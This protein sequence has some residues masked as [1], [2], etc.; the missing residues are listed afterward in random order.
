MPYNDII[1]N[2]KVKKVTPQ[3]NSS[4]ETNFKLD[5]THHHPHDVG[6]ELMMFYNELAM[7][8]S[9]RRTRSE[10]ARVLAEDLEVRR[11]GFA[12]YFE[13]S[14]DEIIREFLNAVA[15]KNQVVMVDTEESNSEIVR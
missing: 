3:Q 5:L 15:E 10:A 2:T 9:L 14:M 8:V 1:E 13:Q 11:I 6:D 12:K 4:A 7:F